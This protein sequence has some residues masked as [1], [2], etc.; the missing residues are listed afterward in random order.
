MVWYAASL[1]GRH[2]TSEDETEILGALAAAII[3][4]HTFTNS[5]ATTDSNRL[6][7]FRIDPR[8]FIEARRCEEFARKTLTKYAPPKAD[9]AE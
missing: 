7:V 8:D 1:I 6:M 2:M 9:D 3:G 4:L 5:P